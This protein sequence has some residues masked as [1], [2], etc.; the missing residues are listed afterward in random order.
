MSSVHDGRLA[1]HVPG[2]SRAAPNR[3]CDPDDLLWAWHRALFH[4]AGLGGARGGVLGV[5]GPP[6]HAGGCTS[7]SRLPSHQRHGGGPGDGGRLLSL[8][9]CP[10]GRLRGC[11]RPKGAGHLPGKRTAGDIRASR[12]QPCPEVTGTPVSAHSPNTRRVLPRTRVSPPRVTL[13]L[14]TMASDFCPSLWLITDGLCSDHLAPSAGRGLWSQGRAAPAV[15]SGP[16]PPLPRVGPEPV[17]APSTGRRGQTT[18]PPRP[19]HLDPA[20][21]FLPLPWPTAWLD[22][23]SP[24]CLLLGPP[25]PFHRLPLGLLG[26]LREAP[27]QDT[28]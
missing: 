6:R 13:G 25:Q 20:P 22:G 14:R 9:P 12:A 18:H 15:P 28:G 16:H 19:A 10:L 17:G 1:C 7:C 8:I 27:T 23:L 26:Q 2:A 3:L 11:S 5:E 4:A 24:R 21:V